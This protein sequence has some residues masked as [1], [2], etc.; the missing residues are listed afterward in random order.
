MKLRIL[1]AS[2]LAIVSLPAAACTSAVISGRAT[3]DGRPL[4]WKHR[5]TG[6]EWNHIE[7]FRGGRYAFTGLVNSRDNARSEVWA[8][9]NERGF[10]IM[11][12][13][14]YNMKPD[15]LA[16]LPEREGEVMKEA[17]GVCAT[18]DEFEE[19]LRNMT[20]PRAVETNFGVIDAEGG[21]A[22]FEVWDY[23]YTKFDAN[24]TALAPNGYLIRSNYSFSGVQDEGMGYIRYQNAEYLL[25]RGYAAGALS[26]E[27]IF[28]S[29]SRSFFNA[30]LD[31]DLLAQRPASGWAIDQDYIPRNSSSASIVVEGVREGENPEATTMWC[32]LGYPPCSYAVAA[33]VCAGDEIADC[34]AATDEGRAPVNRLAVALKRQVFP[35]KRGNGK[36]YMRVD[37]I[38]RAM[39]ALRPFEKASMSEARK[40]R[41]RIAANGCDRKAVAEYNRTVSESVPTAE[42]IVSE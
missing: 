19:F 20:L 42:S 21:A 11:N 24:D 35:V 25:H 30:M 1:I 8:G 9:A 7:H 37:M 36:R 10:A 29:A 3:P 15:S 13:A 27:W 14:S 34:I 32:V 31:G 6:T 41:D 16:N 5:D 17:L 26:P 40:V 38:E 4:L 18:V 12:T 39:T 23:G 22:Y 28:A 33:W 2:M